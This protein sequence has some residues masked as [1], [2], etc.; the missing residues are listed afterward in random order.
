M[1]NT[2]KRLSKLRIF[3]EFWSIFAIFALFLLPTP[4][5]SNRGDQFGRQISMVYRGPCF[6]NE[7]LPKGV[8]WHFWGGV[9]PLL[10]EPQ[11]GLIQIRGRGGS[12]GQKVRSFLTPDRENPVHPVRETR[13]IRPHLPVSH[14]NPKNLKK[15]IFRGGPKK[16][17][18]DDTKIGDFDKIHRGVSKIINFR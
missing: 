4:P 16:P 18:L 8:F 12:R 10:W 6:P 15:C 17:P 9:P 13:Q 2:V 7:I 1:R 11:S 3:R 14:K 5:L